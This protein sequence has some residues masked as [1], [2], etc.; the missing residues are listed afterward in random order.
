M[1]STAHAMKIPGPDHP[2]TIARH[3][4]RVVVKAAGRVIADSTNALVLREA[5]YPPAYY[6]P[7][8]DADMHSLEP[9]SHSTYCPYKG[10]CSYFSIKGS[11]LGRNAVWSY[12]TPYDAVADIKGHLAFYPDRV[13]S[14]E[15]G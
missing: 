1:T 9:S 4:G 6:I 12:E 5:Q 10:P 15:V 3:S 7:R 8:E 14:I 13:D 2:I 11:E